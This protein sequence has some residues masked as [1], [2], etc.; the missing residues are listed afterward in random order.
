MDNCLNSCLY[1]SIEQGVVTKEKHTLDICIPIVKPYHNIAI[2]MSIVGSREKSKGWFYSNFINIYSYYDDKDLVINYD[3]QYFED[4]VYYLNTEKITISTF[5]L[6]QN[7]PIYIIKKI[8]E[9]EKY[10]ALFVDEFY[11]EETLHFGVKHYNHEIMI[12]GY[13]ESEQVLCCAYYGYDLHYKL[14]KVKYDDFI[15]AFYSFEL[16]RDLPF[17]IF[18]F[19]KDNQWMRPYYSIDSQYIK[20]MLKIYINGSNFLYDR[21]HI[22]PLN[23]N[24]IN[25]YGIHI[26]NDLKKYLIDISKQNKSI[27]LRQFYFIY[28]NKIIMQK[29][30]QYL[31]EEHIFLTQEYA[32]Q[33]DKVVQSGRTMLN[34]VMKYNVYVSL[35]KNVEMVKNSILSEIE[36]IEML[37]NEILEKVIENL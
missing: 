23:S 21:R 13:D 16:N 12:Y 27:D 18:S 26:Y 29:R 15:K 20:H 30:L 22:N 10:V 37:E 24:I 8:I 14:R 11:I 1:D 9:L 4:E 25:K 31:F 36:K 33:Y 6:F 19:H 28:E 35:D 3:I 34:S 7:S 32:K 17:L 2:P 5:D